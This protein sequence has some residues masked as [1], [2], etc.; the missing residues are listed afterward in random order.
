MQK[1]LFQF[2]NFSLSITEVKKLG[3]RDICSILPHYFG[4]T[5]SLS[6]S[7]YLSHTNTNTQSHTHT[8]TKILH[9]FLLYEQANANI[10]SGISFSFLH[11][12]FFT[13]INTCTHSHTHPLTHP[14]THTHPPSISPSSSHTIILR[15]QCTNKKWLEVTQKSKGRK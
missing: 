3:R 12:Q 1:K 13:H 2:F 10:E 6:K 7:L 5:L 9:F 8:H 15:Q 11:T 4:N 14:H